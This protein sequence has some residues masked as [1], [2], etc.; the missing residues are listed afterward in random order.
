MLRAHRQPAKAKPAR[1]GADAVPMQ[2]DAKPA[3]NAVTYVGAPK[4]HHLP[5][6]DPPLAPPIAQP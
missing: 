5:E 3:R 1:D 2:I 4:A 6:L